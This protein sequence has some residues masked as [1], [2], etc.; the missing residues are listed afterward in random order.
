MLGAYLGRLA[1]D[2]QIKRNKALAK[3]ERTIN[4]IDPTIKKSNRDVIWCPDNQSP[5]FL[6]TIQGLWKGMEPEGNLVPVIGSY[7]GDSEFAFICSENDFNE[8]VVQN[9]W[10][11]NQESVLIITRCNKQYATLHFHNGDTVG[12]GSLKQVSQEEA[13]Q[14]DAWTYNPEMNAWFIA[15]QENPDIVPPP[16]GWNADYIRVPKDARKFWRD[17]NG[18]HKDAVY[19]EDFDYSHVSDNWELCV[20]IPR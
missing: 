17:K 7:K 6:A 4:M 20:V 5:V 1:I 16:E 19:I 14:H 8:I 10:V 2:A 3:I 9:G 12:I 13:L 18:V 11:D 15:V